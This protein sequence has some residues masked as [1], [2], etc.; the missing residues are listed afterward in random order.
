MVEEVFIELSIII[1]LTLVVSVF[2]KLLRQPL[3]IGYIITGIIISPI[4]LNFQTSSDMFFTFSKIG[5]AFL[6]FIVGMSLN[7]KSIKDLGP[8]SIIV[9]LIQM[10]ITFGLA[11]LIAGYL[12]FSTLSAVYLATAMMFSSTI[13]ITKLLSDKGELE[14]I[15]GKI[16]IGI[17]ILQDL[18]A[19]VAL[20]LI[21]S[22]SKGTLQI[23]NLSYLGIGIALIPITLLIGIYGLPKIIN[24]LAQSQELLFLF[25]LSWCFLLSSLFYY[26]G[27]SIEIG[28]LL[29]GV[30]LSMSPYQ[31]EINS[32][33][34]SLRDFFL[35]IF[36]VYMG[37][38]IQLISMSIFK[39]AMIFS[40]FV[41]LVK[42]LII[43]PII[44]L[45]GYTKRNSFM[46]GLSLVQ[47]S[48]FS[49]IIAGLG[50]LFGHIPQEV[51]SIITFTAL[52]TITFSSYFIIY[53]NKI[54]N[55]FAP[56]LTIFERKTRL[57]Y[58]EKPKRAYDIILF[59]YNRI[60]YKLLQSMK[61]IR[62]KYVVVDFNPVTIKTLK[63][64]KVNCIYGDAGDIEFL[65]S[66]TLDKVKLIVST[67]PNQEINA[68]IAEKIRETN[69]KATIICIAHKIS[70]A[71]ELYEKGADYILMPH[72]L[73]A[74]YASSL[75]EKH[76]LNK[77]GYDKEKIKQILSLK[78]RLI[79]G[80]EHP[81]REGK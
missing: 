31:L 12:G 75:I 78:E 43:T 4:V 34:R 57:K 1:I 29:A 40:A 76:K 52:I 50:L 20:I 67:I 32:K 44:G 73:G 8:V 36:F 23:P 3:I 15:H 18:A 48:E 70:D 41:F 54:Y 30:G 19:I 71:F 2:M 26:L 46:T 28:A 51:F 81:K 27:F 37:M 58:E 53:S 61:K 45:F 59:G 56:Y 11:Y 68:L 10:A 13:I 72:F 77:A 14:T 35:I 69:K 49:L 63:N 5:I 66:L 21:S 64:K 38:K 60:G 7:P 39:M 74:S 25:S 80:H 6:L 65:E 22:F 47:I 16:A 79:I 17:L 55:V 9:G 33:I 42:F 24:K 62:G